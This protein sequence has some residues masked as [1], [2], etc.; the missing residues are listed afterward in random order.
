MMNNM[1]LMKI[2]CFLLLIFLLAAC[3]SGDEDTVAAPAEETG[4]VVLPTA[5]STQSSTDIASPT[6]AVTPPASPPP[7]PP[8]IPPAATFTPPPPT[9]APEPILLISAEDFGTEYN[10]LTG[11]KMEE[12]AVLDRRP[13]ACKLSN[14]PAS[15][16]RPQS[17][18]NSADILYEHITE[19]HLTR[20]TAIFYGT[21]PE[22]I[23]P[24]RSARL[25]DL[26]LP[27][28]YDAAL[29][30]SGA[31]T[32]IYREL[33]ASDFGGR[34]LRS[35]SEGFY[36]TG[37]ETKGYEHTLYADP[38][39]L[40]NE[41]EGMGQNVHPTFGNGMIFDSE[42][43]T[44]GTSATTIDIIYPSIDV[45]WVY[46]AENNRYWRWS[47]DE[48]H[49]DG[50][51]DEQVNFSNLI[52]PIVDTIE[53]VN[54][55]EQ[56]NAENKCVA[57]SLEIQLWGSGPA[58]LYRDGQRYDVT[59]HRDGRYDMLTFTDAD[60]NPFPL[61]IGNSFMQVVPSYLADIVSEHE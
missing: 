20:F 36:R 60:D 55:C 21:A 9:A 14:F 25:I 43:Q 33:S 17:G 8:T 15:Q 48:P 23:G 28:M 2:I 13:I 27:A 18:L 30:F 7:P 12:T 11:E 1:K 22:T 41:L 32:G 4:D 57:F 54:I 44:G 59:W 29:C 56:V 49:L 19:G 24:I 45:Q 40:W 58:T 10:R 61:Q 3:G 6:T 16:T 38:L 50:N 53:D 26:E 46:D 31:G 39:G 35:N 51:S 47:D 52:I 37:D 42:L 34:I 5:V